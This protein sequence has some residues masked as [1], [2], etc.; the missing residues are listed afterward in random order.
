MIRVARFTLQIS[1]ESGWTQRRD[2]Q[3]AGVTV[4]RN[5]EGSK[6]KQGGPVTATKFAEWTRNSECESV[7]LARALRLRPS[8]GR[9]W[10]GL[11]PRRT[12]GRP[13]ASGLQV[14]LESLM[15]LS[16]Y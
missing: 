2:C 11:R 3:N 9:P 7:S 1:S 5:S 12:G 4:G 14:Q 10:P 8:I 13:P 15:K 16:G 6:F